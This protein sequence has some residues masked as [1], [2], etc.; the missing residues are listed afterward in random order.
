MHIKTNKK[1]FL[2]LFL[3]YYFVFRYIDKRNKKYKDIILDV[4]EYNKQ[5]QQLNRY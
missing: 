1:L 3:V 4:I 5:S 2:F